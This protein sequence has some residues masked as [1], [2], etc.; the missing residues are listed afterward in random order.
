MQRLA[1][2]TFRLRILLLLPGLLLAPASAGAGEAD[3]V[4]VK[5]RLA[6]QRL[7]DFHVMVLSNDEGEAAFADRF[8]VLT[9]KGALLGVLELERPEGEEEAQ[10]YLRE[11]RGVAVPPDITEVI[12]RARHH[13]TG[14]G[15]QTMVVRLP[16]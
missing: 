2:L 3:V 15:G 1:R 4:D 16:D 9:R 13:P 10:P 7:Y 8:E 6:G 12:V 14:F 5:V 11:I